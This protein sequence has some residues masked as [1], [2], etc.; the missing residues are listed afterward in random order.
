[1]GR[2]RLERTARFDGSRGV[3]DSGAL[4]SS[5]GLLPQV[6]VV[7][8]LAVVL[9]AAVVAP[10]GAQDDALY[11]DTSPDAYYAVPVAALAEDGVFAGTECDDGFC[12]DDPIDRAT[13]AVWTVRVLDGT[14]PAPVSSTRFGDVDA[15][16]PFAAFIERFA[17]LGVTQGCGDGTVY[18]PDSVV[19]RAEMAVFL[20]RAYDLAEGPD[21]GFS[22]VST[23]AWYAP[24][25][26]RLAASGVTKGC[27]DGTR[28]CP[29]QPTTRAQ[30]ATFL[31]RA[32]TGAVASQDGASFVAV[33]AG[34]SHSCGLYTNGTIECLP[35]DDGDNDDGRN[36]APTGTFSA[37]TAGYSHTCGLRTNASIEC[38]GNNGDGQADAPAG[39]FSAVS[40]G[41]LHTCGLRTNGTI[42]CWGNNDD[43]QTNA[44]TGT[45]SAVSAGQWHTCGLRTNGTIECWGNND[46]G[47]E[48]G[49]ADAPAGTFSAVSAGG[50]HT[51]GLRTNGAIEC[52]GNNSDGQTN[53]PAG[54]F[55]AVS[56][57]QW[58]SCGL[59]ANGSIE[60][61]GY[62]DL[63]QT[64]AP[65]GTFSAVSAGG[66]HTCGLHTDTTI[67]C[68]GNNDNAN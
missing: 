20:S 23:D 67:T 65:A 26:A 15:S 40:A 10:A 13:M 28:F 3:V 52:W 38:W 64:N 9:V 42:E 57:G 37:V 16:H 49:Q 5:D 53:A 22:D 47:S 11:P 4:A 43:G 41:G 33:S 29:D 32:D 51:C 48:V 66:R 34:Y 7:A 54:T 63:G 36:D 31:H 8:V 39:T 24:D 27:G 60:C 2:R 19:N 6:V 56:A 35:N 50:L 55:S 68:W 21:P 18:C 25:V 12:P 45:F 61:W 14:E 58:H 30:M 62:S 59:R 44:P 1:M 17:E 46:D